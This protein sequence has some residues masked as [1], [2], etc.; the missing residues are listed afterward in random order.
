MQTLKSNMRLEL[1]LAN[2]FGR[3][4]RLILELI[5]RGLVGTII[6]N[7]IF[8][9]LVLVKLPH[10]HRGRHT[11]T[12]GR[13]GNLINISTPLIDVDGR[14]CVCVCVA[15]LILHNRALHYSFGIYCVMCA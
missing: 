2:I 11:L 7:T 9:A 14:Q 13:R 8:V 4:L 1:P 6:I 12:Q 15:F 5:Y 3:R 10:Q